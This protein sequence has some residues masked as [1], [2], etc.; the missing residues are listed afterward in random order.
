MKAFARSLRRNQT[1]AER[2][3]W[4][5]L[6]NRQVLNCKFRRQQIFG[7]YIADFLCMEP[8]LVIEIDG[9]QHLDQHK[10]DEKRSQYFRQFGY[11]VLR[12]WN[13]EILQETP[14]VMEKIRLTIIDLIPSPSPSP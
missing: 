4:N 6:R 7:P 10:H 11:R 8:K 13:H 5:Q 2:L 14:A 9:G 3:I 12:F 1:D